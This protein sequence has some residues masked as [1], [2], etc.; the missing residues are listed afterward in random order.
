M[1]KKHPAAVAARKILKKHGL[2][3]QQVGALEF[4][5]CCREY[6]ERP[7]FITVHCAAIQ[8]DLARFEVC[9]LYSEHSEYAKAVLL[10]NAEF[11]Y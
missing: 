1:A 11:N 7:F 5:V 9:H 3:V 8:D 4:Q 6:N 10:H 2:D